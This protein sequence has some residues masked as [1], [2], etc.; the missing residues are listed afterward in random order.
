MKRRAT[1]AAA[2]MGCL[3]LILAPAAGASRPPTRAER[4]AILKLVP[5]PYPRGLAHRVVRISTVNSR[6][7][8]V[9]IRPNR[10]HFHQVQPD[11]G[12]V[13]KMRSGRWILHQGGNGG[14]C[15]M[16][17][18]VRADLHLACY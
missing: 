17:A 8:A 2:L 7:G 5:N 10:G 6:W 18:A 9:Y 11:V 13:Y 14:G 16:S 1:A 15:R 4:R 12:S 3:A